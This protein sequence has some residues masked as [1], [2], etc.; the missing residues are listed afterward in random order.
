MPY[1]SISSY[2]P[3]VVTSFDRE[4]DQFVI[5]CVLVQC[6]VM[7]RCSLSLCRKDRTLVLCWHGIFCTSRKLNLSALAPDTRYSNTTQN[8]ARLIMSETNLV[9]LY[10]CIADIPPCAQAIG[11][12][13]LRECMKSHNCIYMKC[14]SKNAAKTS[15][16][17]K[18]SRMRLRGHGGNYVALIIFVCAMHVRGSGLHQIQRDL[19]AELV[20]HE[21]TPPVSLHVSPVRGFTGL[22]LAIWLRQSHDPP[23]DEFSDVIL[24]FPDQDD[25]YV[26]ALR[27]ASLATVRVQQKQNAGP[28]SSLVTV[29]SRTRKKGS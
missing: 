8:D 15:Q 11:A 21:G 4:L 16:I 12:I 1:R 29:N 14:V 6:V 25:I 27:E 23:Q 26:P 2:A 5:W 10:T 9:C 7:L 20:F 24:A 13:G 22:E 18:Q 28:A 3:G 19:K 17:K